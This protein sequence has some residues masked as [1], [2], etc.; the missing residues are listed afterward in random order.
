L[1][2][3]PGT[4]AAAIALGAHQSVANWDKPGFGLLSLLIAVTIAL[5]IYWSYSH[6]STVASWIGE[7]ATRVVTRLSAFLL[8]CVGVQIMLTGVVDSLRPLMSSHT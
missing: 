4:I 6:A 5:T 1:T 7:Q 8:L 3:G 2:T